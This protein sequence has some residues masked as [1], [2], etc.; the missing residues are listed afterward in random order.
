MAARILYFG[1]DECRRVSVLQEAGF[2]VEGCSSLITLV[3]AL[4]A[5]EGTDAVL[6]S[7]E[8]REPSWQEI[9]TIRERSRAPLILFQNTDCGCD[10]S[11]F[12][13]VIPA[14]T[15]PE[16]WLERV[17]TIVRQSERLRHDAAVL[18]HESAV[19]RESSAAARGRTQATIHEF[20]RT[21]ANAPGRKPNGSPPDG[22]LD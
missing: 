17:S 10:E 11:Q 21:K 8:R 13:G 1:E 20:R 3:T 6:L 9:Q 18:R 19:L 16:L 15:P 14:L 2:T 7:E 22:S 4:G 12:D 5:G